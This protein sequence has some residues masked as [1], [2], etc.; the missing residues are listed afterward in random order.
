M[1]PGYWDEKMNWHEGSVNAEYF[2]IEDFINLIKKNS[3][4]N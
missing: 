4:D 2:I 3:F 1:H